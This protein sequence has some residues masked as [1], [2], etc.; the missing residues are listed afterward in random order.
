MKRMYG[1][2]T[3]ELSAI[4]NDAVDRMGTTRDGAFENS[5]RK[6]VK[7]VLVKPPKVSTSF[8]TCNPWSITTR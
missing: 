6:V 4:V 5:S 1:Q 3:P 2:L 7:N 8:I